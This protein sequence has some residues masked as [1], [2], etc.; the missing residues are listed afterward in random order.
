MS[1]QRR[2][3]SKKKEVEST[4]GYL[5]A[6]V[7]LGNG[8]CDYARNDGKECEMMQSDKVARNKRD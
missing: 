7:F 6:I 3:E 8:F 1:F 4:Y 2:R 5:F